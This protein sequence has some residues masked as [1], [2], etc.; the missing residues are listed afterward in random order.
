MDYAAHPGLQR[1]GFVSRG[2]LDP[3]ALTRIR[4]A[5]PA[6]LPLDFV[7]FLTQTGGGSFDALV[8]CRPIETPPVASEGLV[9]IDVLLGAGADDA[10]PITEVWTSARHV[11]VPRSSL[12]IATT[13]VGDYICL[14]AVGDETQ[15]TYWDHDGGGEYAVAPSFL[16][17]L[18]RLELEPEEDDD[19]DGFIGGGLK[20]GFGR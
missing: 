19:V 15:V 9:S 1:L 4:D 5:A 17:F 14:R 3:E 13:P 10:D 12:P 11:E 6:P 18:D 16:D 2:P 7:E 20:P 8:A